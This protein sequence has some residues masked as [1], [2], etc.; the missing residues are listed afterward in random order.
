[1][2]ERYEPLLALGLFQWNVCYGP[3]FHHHEP[4]TL[5]GDKQFDGLPAELR[6]KDT[7]GGD[8]GAAALDV[9]ERDGAGFDSRPGLDIFGDP[10]ADPAQ[11]HRV[12]TG[13]VD[14]PD[15][16]LASFGTGAF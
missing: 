12:R 4:R 3:S 1:M 11:A 14:S 15:D 10:L 8:G 6:C 16:L 9:A 13:C 2:I 5:S 7:V